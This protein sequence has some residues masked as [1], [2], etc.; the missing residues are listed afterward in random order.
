MVMKAMSGFSLWPTNHWSELRRAPSVGNA[1]VLPVI[2]TLPNPVSAWIRTRQRLR[3][4][5]FRST[6]AACMGY[7][8]FAG[9]LR[10]AEPPSVG[11]PLF[12][13][14]THEFRM[15]KSTLYQHRTA[16]DREARSYRYD[17]VG[18]VSYALK[19][20]APEAWATTVRVTGIASGRIPSP[21]RYRAFFASLAEKPQPGWQAITKVS[22]L[23]C[24][25]VVVWEHKTKTSVGHAVVIG[26][27]PVPGPGESWS[28]E[29]YDSTASP[30]SNDSRRDDER[31]HVLAST[32]RRSGLGHGVMVLISDPV[33][34]ALTGLRWS[35]EARAI[36]V[37]IA[38][39]RPTS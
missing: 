25:D 5:F 33:S 9:T 38:A 20:A 2:L 30:H 19:H 39:G 10:G 1:V 32:G 36:Q 15:M 31:A 4:F 13:E 16:V 21:L 24:G 23:R 34:G 14:A 6:A 3:L 11:G 8:W 22:D 26:G 27:V 29:V 7:G 17:C 37:P 35:A 28:V 18:F 12:H